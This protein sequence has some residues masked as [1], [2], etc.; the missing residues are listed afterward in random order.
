MLLERLIVIGT[1]LMGASLAL[2]AKEKN[3]AQTVVGIDSREG[4][5]AKARGAVDSVFD[6]L[7]DLGDMPGYTAI[8]VATPVPPMP[9]IFAQIEAFADEQPVLWITDL[10][11]TKA[12]VV[13]AAESLKIMR[14]RFVSSHPMAGSEKQGARN[15]DARIFDEAKVLISPLAQSAKGSVIDVEAFW[16]AMGTQPVMLPIDEHDILL[17]HISHLPHA[18][19]Y[20]LASSLADSSM[21]GSAQALHGGGLRDTTRIAGS[22]PELWADIFLENRSALLSAWAQWDVHQ[23]MFHEA[24]DKKDRTLLIELMTRASHWRKGF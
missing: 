11:S 4:E 22:S 6:R 19:A 2:R 23:K 24:L 15:A 13:R 10:G 3:V 8:V 9:E 16:I 5:A 21:A 17:A 12:G 14:K 20:M 1:G 18:V 7:L